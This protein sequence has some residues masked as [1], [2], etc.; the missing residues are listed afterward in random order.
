ME[1]TWAS[2]GRGAHRGVFRVNGPRSFARVAKELSGALPDEFRVETRQE[3]K[4]GAGGGSGYVDLAE[5][6]SADLADGEFVTHEGEI[7]TRAEINAQHPCNQR[8]KTTAP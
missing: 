2:Y 4:G 7:M 6:K 3:R 1:R 5:L 8:K